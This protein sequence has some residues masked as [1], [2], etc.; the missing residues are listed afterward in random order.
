MS[1]LFLGM[2]VMQNMVFVWGSSGAAASAEAEA[3]PLPIIPDMEATEGTPRRL[4]SGHAAISNFAV[5]GLMGN[6]IS[7]CDISAPAGI[8]LT[9]C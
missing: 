5:C 9:C 3:M 2:Q 7:T 4:A 6:V 1:A 8:V